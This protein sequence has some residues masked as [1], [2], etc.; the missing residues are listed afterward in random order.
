[1]SVGYVV[2]FSGDFV[3]ELEFDI[4]IALS[5]RSSDI[6]LGVLTLKVV[7]SPRPAQ[8]RGLPTVVSYNCRWAG[9]AIVLSCFCSFVQ[10]QS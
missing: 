10:L 7:G 5:G 8:A 4:G 9:I 1:M 3:V 2:A 6:L